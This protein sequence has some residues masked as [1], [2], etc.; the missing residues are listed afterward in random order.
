MDASDACTAAA[1]P[2]PPPGLEAVEYLASSLRAA[3]LPQ[4]ALARRKLITSH[5]SRSASSSRTQ[6]MSG[7]TARHRLSTV[8]LS[9]I[10]SVQRQTVSA[11]RSNSS[12]FS[13]LGFVSVMV[14]PWVGR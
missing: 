9:P 11:Y 8:A 10:Q 6:A 1:S 12:K 4:L 14:A 13:S 5:G 2:S 7:I 3:G